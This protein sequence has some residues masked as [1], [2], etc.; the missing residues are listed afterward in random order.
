MLSPSQNTSA[1]YVATKLHPPHVRIDTIRRPHLEEMLCRFVRTLPLTLLSAPAGYGKTTLLSVLPSIIPDYPMAWITLDTEDND[2]IRFM[3]LLAITLQRLHPDCG[4]SV[5]PIISG[6]VITGMDMKHAM[7][8][9]IND[10]VHYLSEPFIL[11]LDDLH[12]VTEPAVHVVLDYLLEQLPSNLHIAIGTRHD[13][14]L[15]LTRL[16]A[17]R[18]LGELRRNDLSLDHD[19]SYQLL[20]DTLGLSLSSAEVTILQERTEGW[21]GVLC[22][23]AGPL[24]RMGT[25]KD[26]AHLMATI[27]H[28]ERQALDFLA[29]EIILHL[30]EDIR[31]FLMQTSILA[32]I[33][34]VACQAVTGR[35]DAAEVLQ[36]LYRRNLAIASLTTESEGEPV[37]R[38]HAL[39]AR[40]L[41]LQLERELSRE[42]IITLHRK[43]A[44]VQT[45]P[46]RAISHYFSACLWAQAAQLMVNSGMELLHRGMTETVRHWYSGLP[47]ETRNCYPY[48]ITLMARCEIHR[49]EYVAADK[50]LEQAREIFVK[51]G[52]A[53]GEGDALTSLIT[54]CYHK[55]DRE[56]AAA[57]VERAL[58]LPLNPMG[59]VA[60]RLAQ[61]WMNMYHG[62]W[63]AVCTNIHE[64][65]AIPNATGDRRAD[66][67]GITY[68]T[69]PMAVMPGCLQVIERYCNEV[70]SHTLPDTAWSLG[71][72]ELGTWPLLFQGK[73]DEALKRAEAAEVL[74]Q[75]LGGF[76]FVG[77]D[78]PILL[79]VL[80]LARGDLEAA[81]RRTDKL[82]QHVDKASLSSKGVGMLYLHAVGRSLALLGRHDE[83]MIM[84]Q[85]LGALDDSY[86]LTDYLLNHLK[87]LI[88]LL[89]GNQADAAIALERAAE[90]EIQLPMAQVGG[91]ARLLQ[92]RLLLE[93]GLSDRAFDVA[94][95]VLKAWSNAS[96][97]GYALLD[98]LVILPVLKLA[99]ERNCNGATRMLYLFSEGAQNKDESKPV[100]VENTRFEVLPEP[101]TPRECDVLRLLIA[102]HT[103]LQI[104]IELHITKETV[105]SHVAHIFRKLDVRSRTQA[106][107][108]ARELGF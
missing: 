5:W 47:T 63:D 25:L 81:G 36:G 53:K 101:L 17:R 90:L 24:G 31:Q 14:P 67:V 48:L 1:W 44:A 60:T 71:A 79:S 55:N 37:Y 91:S 18:Q 86:P 22:L 68:I 42:K 12:F 64:G 80:Y 103:N 102:G 54:L 84:Q 96:T 34:P 6:G 100:P 82:I 26:R 70:V 107:I 59:Q 95:P 4:H 97:P 8:I 16:A 15:R 23:L 89:T 66:I 75:R 10:I 13:P 61:V 29:E 106:A 87:G 39:F 104:S 40:L 11:V 3:G 105:K 65:L 7:S 19:E 38:Y 21:P 57:Y 32:E 46:S 77:N 30:P 58:K 62:N 99:V 27:A 9:L 85:R 88:A 56:S 76:P 51:E 72:Q 98:G 49:G 20:N 73:T 45:T 69:A 33:T 92:A 83:A 41:N 28:T 94:S 52:D 2:P 50:L 35:D 74:R 78:L 43:A 93:Q 108:C